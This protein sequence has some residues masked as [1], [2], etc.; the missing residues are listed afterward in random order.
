MGKTQ[1]N[2]RFFFSGC[3]LGLGCCL[4]LE[5]YI[6]KYLS[7]LKKC[8]WL[9]C[10]VRTKTTENYR[11]MIKTGLSAPMWLN[12]TR[13]CFKFDRF[14]SGNC[15]GISE[16]PTCA[17]TN[18]WTANFRDDTHKKDGDGCGMQWAILDGIVENAT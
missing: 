14:S 10:G 6:I 2:S 16:N 12:N 8:P 1:N 15:G 18:S 5:S 9:S 17:Y 7:T 4:G 11:W 3:L 13:I